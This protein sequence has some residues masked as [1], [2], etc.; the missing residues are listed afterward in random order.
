MNHEDAYAE[1]V[2]EEVLER[3]ASPSSKNARISEDAIDGDSENSPLIGS[4]HA[5]RGVHKRG[6]S[7]QRAINEPW[8][9]AHR[10]GPQPWYK[11][12]SVSFQDNRDTL[13]D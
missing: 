2:Q 9:G 1:E 13:V 10:G 8:T 12:P 4:P 3:Q 11:K 7:Y 5:Q 6:Y